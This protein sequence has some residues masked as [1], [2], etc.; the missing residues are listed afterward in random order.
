LVMDKC[1]YARLLPG[2]FSQETNDGNK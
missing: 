2:E 1:L